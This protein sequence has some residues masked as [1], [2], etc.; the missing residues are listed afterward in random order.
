MICSIESFNKIKEMHPKVSHYLTL[1]TFRPNLILKN[2]KRPFY[3]DMF[4]R[5]DIVNPKTGS[6]HAFNVFLKCPNC[7]IT[8]VNVETG[9]MD[10][11]GILKKLASW[12]RVDECNPY[13]SFF[14][15]YTINHE[16]GYTV[17]SG[18]VIDLLSKKCK[19]TDVTPFK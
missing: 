11:V 5:F 1:Q 7:T 2:V 16:A 18:E 9:T 13:Y 6:R 15:M 12:R 10:E 4:D 8:N 14:G 19:I 3:E 17:K